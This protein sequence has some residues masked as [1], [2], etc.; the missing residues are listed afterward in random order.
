M[1]VAE[2]VGARVVRFARDPSE[3]FA[4]NVDRVAAAMTPRTRVVCVTNLHN[5]SGVRASDAALRDVAELAGGQGAHLLVDEVYAPFDSFVDAGGVFRGSARRLAPN[6]VVVSSLTKCYGLGP[7]R[8]GWMLGPQ[9]VV[10]RA[11][12]AMTACCGALP[13][14]H[15]NLAAYH[16]ERIGTCSRNALRRILAGKRM[17]V[18]AWVESMSPEGISWSDPAE[19]LFAFVTLPGRGDITPMIEP[20]AR[21]RQILVAA[22][23]VFRRSRT[24]FAWRGRR[25][26]DQ[27]DEGL[28]RV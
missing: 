26:D 20:A 21:D 7:R 14:E 22:G 15:G 12:N 27:L 19:G 18:G 2:C 24:G 8:I 6:V 13:A 23:V 25:P 17:R 5:P 4:L 11:E 9:E 10:A 28:A 1:R 3:R 16:F